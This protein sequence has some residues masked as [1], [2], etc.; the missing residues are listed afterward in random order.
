MRYAL[1]ILMLAGFNALAAPTTRPSNS[2]TKP[3]TKP[4]AKPKQRFTL[5]NGAIRF[6]VP[7][8]W[9]E[10]DRTDDEKNAKYNSPDGNA[11]ILVGI[12]PQEFPIPQNN[13]RFLMQMKA[14]LLA[15]I[16]QNLEANHMEALFG[17]KSETDDRFLLRIHEKIK[18]GHDT[19]DQVHLYRAAGL[20]LLMV[21]TVVKSENKD[22]I[23]AFHTMGEDLCLS[24][25]L[26]AAD[27]K[28]TVNEKPPKSPTEPERK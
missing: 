13:A 15:A 4:A 26:G 12:T 24:M 28:G 19:L 21:T 3:A 7:M 22:E 17:P 8:D 14:Q 23:K 10:S 25:V 6:M 11:S 1:A 9:T 5:M 20:D 16:K 27:K 2:A 18:S